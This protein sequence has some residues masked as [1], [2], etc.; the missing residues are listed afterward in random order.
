MEAIP[1]IENLAPEP[2]ICST[3]TQIKIAEVETLIF[4]VLGRM[5]KCNIQ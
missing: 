4:R 3:V 2:I 5:K 1:L